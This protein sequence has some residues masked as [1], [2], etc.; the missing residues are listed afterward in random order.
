MTEGCGSVTPPWS[1]ASVSAAPP[2]ALI[3]CCYWSVKSE[4]AFSLLKV[5][6][7]LVQARCV[8]DSRV[9]GFMMCS[10]SEF[11]FLRCGAA[12]FEL[13]GFLWRSCFIRN[14]GNIQNQYHTCITA[15]DFLYFLRIGHYGPVG[16][17]AVPPP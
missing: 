9:F 6:L 14:K 8:G 16:C 4:Y 1:A 7:V 11:V 2:L 3:T 12:Q 15:L 10:W 13:F 17:T 5:W